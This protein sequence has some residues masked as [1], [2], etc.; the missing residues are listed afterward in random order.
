MNVSVKCFATL[1]DADTCDFNESRVYDLDTGAKVDSLLNRLAIPEAS[2]KLV[3]VNGRQAGFDARL[4]DGDRVGLAP[5]VG[6]M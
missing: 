1:A 3:F 6:G 4:S 5:V 2:V